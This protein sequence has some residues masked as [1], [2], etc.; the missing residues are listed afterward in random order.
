MLTFYH[1]WCADRA[2][3]P[4]IDLFC[5][6]ELQYVSFWCSCGIKSSYGMYENWHVVISTQ[7]WLSSFTIGSLIVQYANWKKYIELN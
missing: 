7:I 2:K 5:P 6:T 1:V 4:E 3:C